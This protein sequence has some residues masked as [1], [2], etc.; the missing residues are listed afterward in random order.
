MN[1]RISPLQYAFIYRI[2]DTECLLS[3]VNNRQLKQAACPW[4]YRSGIR[5]NRLID[6]SPSDVQRSISIRQVSLTACTTDKLRL[7]PSIRFCDMPT[8][9]ASLASKLWI[10][11]DQSHTGETGFVG[12]ELFGMPV[13]LL[14]ASNL[15]PRANA[16]QFLDRNCPVRAFGCSNDA[17]TDPVIGVF[18]KTSLLSRQ[19]LQLAFRRLCTP[20]SAVLL[21]G[22]Y[23]AFWHDPL[24]YQNRCSH[25]YRWQ[26]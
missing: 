19:A 8:L 11:L 7:R 15:S 1:I 24:S 3:Y 10:D 5:D 6:C 18:L 23:S 17:L 4:R 2:I 20:I 14:F 16:G 13:A 22:C 21:A 25:R 9:I 26:D 12:Y